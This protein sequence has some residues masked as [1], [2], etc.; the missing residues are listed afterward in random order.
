MH[1][2][3]TR[4]GRS[5]MLLAALAALIGAACG[6]DYSTS[7]PDRAA[8]TQLRFV[9]Q[10]NDAQIDTWEYPDLHEELGIPGSMAVHASVEILDA[11]GVRATWARH[12][13]TL[14]LGE[15]PGDG[16]LYSVYESPL[17]ANDGVAV[18]ELAINRAGSGYT[19]VASAD[20]MTGATSDAFTV[21]E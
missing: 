11:N 21:T 13:I 8:A 19:L 12:G 5:S 4:L 1:H 15:N 2:T 7:P 20:G 10:P 6:R 14:A 3:F 16:T 17:Y 9:L 18:F